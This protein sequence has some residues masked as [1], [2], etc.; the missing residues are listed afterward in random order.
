VKTLR[1][2]VDPANLDHAEA[3]KAIAHAADIL[4]KGGLVAFPTETVYGLGANALDPVT[5]ARIFEAKQRPAWDPV[6]VH[7]AGPVPS[8]PMLDSL[9]TVISAPTRELI[10]HFW[11]GPL[12]LLLP[13]SAAVP[14]AVTAGRPLVGVRM[15]AHPVAFELIQQAGVPIAAPSAN[16]FGHISPTTAAHVLDDLDGRIDAVLDAGPT[17]HGVESTVLDPGQS[18]MMIYRPGAITAEQ[19]RAVAGPVDFYAPGPTLPAGPASA[20]PSPGVGIRHYAP[21]ARLVLVDAPLAALASRIAEEAARH[22]SKRLGFLLPLEVSAPE[23]VASL[24]AAI[25]FP[26]G[27]WNAPEELAQNLYAGLR[28]LDAQGCSVIV[29]PL[30]PA[31]GLGSAIRD[32]LFKAARS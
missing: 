7:I 23:L 18:P 25:V 10:V 16:A 15:P 30:P 2:S 20:L 3:R 9:V 28:A 6:I 1:L 4:R 19:L 24:P 12:T 21:R 5:V 29:C 31:D 11:P 13:R 14:D 17:L 8:N 26:W 22:A 27:H 32:R